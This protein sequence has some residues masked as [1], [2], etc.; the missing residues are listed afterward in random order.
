M[1]SASTPRLRLT[2]VWYLLVLV[3]VA[4]SER[5]LAHGLIGATSDVAGF[6]LIAAASLGRI[7]TSTFIAG[8]KDQHLV[9]SGPYARCRNPLY[10]LSLVGGVGVGLASGSL[11]L[12]AATLI[13]LLVLYLR[14]ISVEERFL[15]ERH[16]E[17]FRRY[18]A[19]VP[20]LWPRAPVGA[21]PPAVEVNV[22]VFAKAF[23]DAGSFLLIYAIV[24]L[25]DALRASGWLPTIVKL[26]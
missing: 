15:G 4:L 2:L 21:T 19:Q 8:L 24:Q 12:T 22:A 6:V 25:L 1:S 18:C 5:P 16:G 7:W 26:W 3:L 13:V 10:A 17:A 11:I 23:R 14:A 9:T 20:R